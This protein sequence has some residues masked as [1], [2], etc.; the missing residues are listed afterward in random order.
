MPYF[1]DANNTVHFLDD[2][3]FSYLLPL[4]CQPITDGE[5]ISAQAPTLAKVRE[6]KIASLV[7]FRDSAIVADITINNVVY[8][9][10]EKFKTYVSRILNQTGR[11]KP[12]PPGDLIRAKDR[13]KPVV[14]IALLSQIEDVLTSQ[15]AAAWSKFNG[16][17]D[18]VMAA[19]DAATVGAIVW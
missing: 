7:S 17:V 19:T 13:S 3:K 18:Q 10:D 9:A 5:A 14:T 12:L 11:G 16:L 1:K 4:G 2:A 15:E 8:P 6:G